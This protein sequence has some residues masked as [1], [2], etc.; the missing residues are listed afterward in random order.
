MIVIKKVISKV[1]PLPVKNLIRRDL[2]IL[3]AARSRI[4]AVINVKPLSENGG[5]DRGLTIHRYY[6]EQFLQ[7]FSSNISGYCLEF[8]KDHYTTRFGGAA[9]TKLDILHM[10]DSN[11]LATIVA[12]LTRPNQIPGNVFDCIICTYVLH[13]VF[14][15]N[16]VILELHRILKPGGILLI[17]VPHIQVW[18]PKETTGK[19][20]WRFTPEGLRLTLAKVFKPE[21]ITI[22]SYGN[23]LTAA[24]DI[25]CLV[26]H[27]FTKAELGNHDQRYAVIV[28]A[29]A[30]K[31]KKMDK[32][33]QRIME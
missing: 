33:A 24:G 8:Q 28:S 11:P 30:I 23:S 2:K 27:E 4:K 29:K 26:S 22:R 17:T 31:E 18:N 12:D 5:F 21:N 20:C 7:E 15:L 13:I 32:D 14:E 9:V 19:E 16:K 25:R 6:L 10:D 3:R 1:L